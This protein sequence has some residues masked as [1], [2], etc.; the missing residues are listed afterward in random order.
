MYL[1]KCTRAQICTCTC[2]YRINTFD[3][4]T[5]WL[6]RDKHSQ[7]FRQQLNLL[8]CKHSIYY[9]HWIERNWFLLRYSMYLTRYPYDICWWFTFYAV[10]LSNT[11]HSTTSFDYFPQIRLTSRVY[12]YNRPTPNYSIANTRHQNRSIALSLLEYTCTEK[13]VCVSSKQV[14]LYETIWLE[15]LY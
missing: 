4:K 1:H 6:K 3:D 12:I 11:L 10:S 14:D 15:L 2:T 8:T 5:V 7:K 13:R 9:A